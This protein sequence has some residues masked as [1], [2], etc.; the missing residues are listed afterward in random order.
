MGQDR[1]LVL[2]VPDEDRVTRRTGVHR[3][4]AVVPHPINDVR[5]DAIPGGEDF[6]AECEYPRFGWVPSV[7][8]TVR[9]HADQIEGETLGTIVVVGIELGGVPAPENQPSAVEGK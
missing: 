2:A 9:P 8:L 3:T 5:D 1:H 4:R 7:C 6:A